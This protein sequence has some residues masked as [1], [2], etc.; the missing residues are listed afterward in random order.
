MAL[1]D[2]FECYECIVYFLAHL[3]EV[4]FSATFKLLTEILRMQT[5]TNMCN[6]V[7][8]SYIYIMGDAKIFA[9]HEWLL[10]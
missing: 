1:I 9:Q 3:S 6:G 5:V 10:K 2:E 8:K 7:R 4:T